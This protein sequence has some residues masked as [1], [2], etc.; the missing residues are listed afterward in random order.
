MPT[1]STEGYREASRRAEAA[2]E[3]D[4]QKKQAEQQKKA[5]ESAQRREAY[6]QASRRLEQYKRSQDQKQRPI[7]E[8]KREQSKA[9]S[10]GREI[11]SI[12]TREE[13]VGD[14]VEVTREVKSKTSREAIADQRKQA[15][16][17]AVI[18]QFRQIKAEGARRGIEVRQVQ[19][20]IKRLPTGESQIEV[21]KVRAVERPIFGTKTFSEA[22][23]EANKSIEQPQYRK[24]IEVG[25]EDTIT[26]RPPPGKRQYQ[27]FLEDRISGGPYAYER[28]PG[29]V[30]GNEKIGLSDDPIKA[31]TAPLENIYTQY[32]VPSGRG[33]GVGIGAL[34]GAKPESSIKRAS[35]IGDEARAAEKPEVAGSFFEDVAIPVGQRGFQ[36]FYDLST[37]GKQQKGT[38]EFVSKEFQEFGKRLEGEKPASVTASIAGSV[39]AFL[40]DALFKGGSRVAKA[41]PGIFGGVRKAE[42]A[43]DAPRTIEFVQPAKRFENVGVNLGAGTAATARQKPSQVFKIETPVTKQQVKKITTLADIDKRMKDVSGGAVQS[44]RSGQSTILVKPQKTEATTFKNIV[45]PLNVERA[46]TGEVKTIARVGNQIRSSLGIKLGAGLGQVVSAKAITKELKRVGVATKQ[47]VGVRSIRQSRQ[48]DLTSTVQLQGFRIEPI[49]GQKTTPKQSQSQRSRVDV[50]VKQQLNVAQTFKF[51]QV[52]KQSTRTLAGTRTSQF[53]RSQFADLRISRVTEDLIIK[54]NKRS[55]L[56]FPGFGPTRKQKGRKKERIGAELRSFRAGSLPL[57]FLGRA[58]PLARSFEK[59]FGEFY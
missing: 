25:L 26:N 56:S 16:Q 55:V 42:A 11:T 17:Q 29:E 54:P 18:D 1:Q 30:L 36:N 19:S 12:T 7:Q 13:M 46:A 51:G 3:A 5:Q 48:S 33:A 22:R 34:F 2:A 41:I 31:F 37:V 58:N 23:A 14:Q 21:E 27:V 4:R 15:E 39:V 28:S 24:I 20:R 59:R 50:M 53:T 8:F 35:Q 6:N 57:A 45:I 38:S 49:I 10:E 47:S 44:G 40:P 43:T 9:R 32:I 52:F